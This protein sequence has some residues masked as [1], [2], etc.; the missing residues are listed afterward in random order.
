MLN[1]A[2]SSENKVSWLSRKLIEDIRGGDFQPGSLLPAELEL[3]QRY[4]VSRPTIRRAVQVLTEKQQLVKLPNRGVL[5]VDENR[6][7]TFTRT[8]QIAFITPA[9]N[10]ETNLYTRGISDILN[11]ERY[12]LATYC[13]HGNL[14]KYEIL[15]EQIA[16]MKPAGVILQ[17]LS[18]ELGRVNGKLFAQAGIPVVATGQ[19]PVPE[20]ECDRV[21]ISGKDNSKKMVQYIR[22]KEYR[23][24]AYLSYF[25]KRD[26]YEFIDPFR[27]ELARVGLSLPEER[28]FLTEAPHGYMEPPDPYID[29]YL[30]TKRLLR[31]GF[32]CEVLICGHDYVSVGALRAI[33]EAGIRVPQEMKVISGMRNPVA[34][35]APLRLTGFDFGQVNQGRLAAELLTR[36]IEGYTGA[37][38]VHYSSVELIQGET[39]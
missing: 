10:D 8:R 24:L 20:L 18:E 25:P 23:D 22:R 3:A 17:T 9:L 27:L 16:G 37:I 29:A 15:I 6:P 14:K 39:A 13:S 33:Q 21:V 19:N 5:I 26:C 36:R 12:T 28:V 7:T 30:L 1:M 38:E 31:E 2:V 4:K 11:P 34:G 35:I 32:R